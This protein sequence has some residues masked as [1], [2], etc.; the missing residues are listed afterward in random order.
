MNDSP[1]AL[2]IVL[3]DLGR[4][5]R[6]LRHA[7][8]LSGMGC[9]VDLIG[10]GGAE[11][12]SAVT[13]DGRI[14]IRR[15]LSFDSLRG[16][17]PITFLFAASLR[18]MA[19]AF[20][21]LFRLI[22]IRRPRV[23]LLQNP[24][25]LPALPLV[26]LFARIWRARLIVDWH[27]FTG[28]MLHLRPLSAGIVH[29]VQ[30]AEIAFARRADAHLTVSH[31]MAERMEREFGLQPTIVLD[32][33]ADSFVPL[34]QQHGTRPA[35]IIVPTSWGADEDFA[36]LADA[37][38]ICD[39]AI[40]QR[41]GNV[42]AVTGLRFLITG[43]GEHRAEYERRFSSL[44]L[45]HVEIRTDWFSPDDYPR[46]LAS[47]DLGVS[48]HRSASGVDLAAKVPE[49]LACGLP[50]CALDYGPAVREQINEGEDGFLYSNASQLAA[51]IGSLCGTWPLA[52]A[53]DRLRHS[54]RATPRPR[55]EEEWNRSARPVIESALA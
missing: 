44:H 21:L 8:S 37:A 25:A 29:L 24:P 22:G 32:R 33:A 53:L 6:M 27:N 15:V 4:S 16:R 20:A 30:K 40:V 14:R 10:F 51:M 45:R 46:A 11:L 54:I 9:S 50:V 39:E 5:P 52:P 41:N 2:V 3:G 36:L 55:W 48:L 23:V 38:Q 31:A 19:L 49:M 18:Q 7:Q 34:D 1:R 13:A 43:D 28:A 26:L 47:A 42:D 12:P 17:T 35:T